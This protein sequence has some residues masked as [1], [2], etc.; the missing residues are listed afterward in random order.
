[1]ELLMC[2]LKERNQATRDRLSALTA[3]EKQLS[4]RQMELRA[5]VME[6]RDQLCVKEADRGAVVGRKAS[7]VREVL[8]R[9]ARE[10]AMHAMNIAQY[11]RQQEELQHGPQQVHDAHRRYRICV[12]IVGGVFFFVCLFR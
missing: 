1:M 10:K 9:A 2:Q 3:E 11:H 12:L 6:W 5:A 8:P 4:A 7:I